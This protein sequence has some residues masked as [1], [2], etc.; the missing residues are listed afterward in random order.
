MAH[1][2]VIGNHL[3]TDSE[4]G[5]YRRFGSQVQS[6]FN[7]QIDKLAGRISEVPLGWHHL[8]RDAV[9]M[10]R[11]VDCPKRNGIEFSEP[12]IQ[13]GEF[14]LSVYFGPTDKTVRAIVRKLITKTTCTCC[15][16]G[17]GIGAVLRKESDRVLCAGCYVRTDLKS[18]LEQWLEIRASRNIYK[19]RLLM[20][21][22]ELP[23]NIQ[24]VIPKQKIKT[25]HLSDVKPIK[26]VTPGDVQ[27]Q[28]G[29]LGLMMRYLN[30]Q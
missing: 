16:C 19:S 22:K 14:R 27:D 17:S 11:A 13:F 12:E 23:L 20:E 24:F 4:S 2:N 30:K 18:E 7:L 6:R 3:I 1:A 28:V 10:L 8:F 25:L 9:R 15:V 29:K 21:F 5:D 26:F